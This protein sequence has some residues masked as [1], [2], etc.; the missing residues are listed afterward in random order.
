LELC[1]LSLFS[2]LKRLVQTEKGSYSS[3]LFEQIVLSFFICT[4]VNS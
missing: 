1:S 3:N 2:L 4:M